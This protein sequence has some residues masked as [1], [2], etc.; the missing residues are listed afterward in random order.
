MACLLTIAVPTYNRAKFLRRLLELLASE[1]KGLENEV[2]LLVSDNASTDET[3]AVCREMG[4]KLALQYHRQERNVGFDHNALWIVENAKGEYL[5]MFGDDDL[6]V[7]GSIGRMLAFLKGLK[8]PLSCVLA[9]YVNVEGKPI[10]PVGSGLPELH[11]P[12]ELKGDA[13]LVDALGLTGSI[14][15]AVYRTEV[16][17][18]IAG[19]KTKRQSDGSLLVRTPSGERTAFRHYSQMFYA[20]ECALAG[21]KFALYLQPCMRAIWDGG[22]YDAKVVMLSN[23][24]SLQAMQD[25]ADYFPWI[26]AKPG[27]GLGS[28]PYRIMQFFI[29][30]DPAFDRETHRRIYANADDFVAFYKKH[31]NKWWRLFWLMR[32]FHS[33]FPFGERIFWTS[34]VLFNRM[35]G[36]GTFADINKKRVG[37]DARAT[38]W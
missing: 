22:Y 13:R 17:Q 32:Q 33:R 15:G 37:T 31:G 5:W 10:M 27:L 19:E 34:Y 21:P 18:K 16:V 35:R 6:L 24:R 3:E 23:E 38:S 4:G 30:I 36:R 14:G 2:E 29:Y 1:M 26:Y 7:E 11:E 28:S 12:A 20:I 25:F 8:D 9:N